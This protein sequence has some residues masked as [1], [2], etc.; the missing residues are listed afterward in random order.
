M[1]LTRVASFERFLRDAAGI[2]VDKDD[3]KRYSD[4]VHYPDLRPVAP[5]P[6]DHKGLQECIHEFERLER[7]SSSSRS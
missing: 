3:L 5:R 2:D 4:F 6:P 1:T 7:P